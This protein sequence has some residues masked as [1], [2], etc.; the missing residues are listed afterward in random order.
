[1]KLEPTVETVKK[2]LSYSGHSE[3]CGHFVGHPSEPCER[4]GFSY[5]SHTG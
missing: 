4:C 2:E 1:M 5:Y 3:Q